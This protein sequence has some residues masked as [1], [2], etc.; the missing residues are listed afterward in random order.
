MKFRPIIVDNKLQELTE[1][2]TEE[3]PMSMDE[4][5]VSYENC[6]EVLHWHYEIQIA[7]VTKGSVLFR[8]P[9]GEFLIKTGQGIFINSGCLHEAVPTDDS[10]SVYICIN[11]HPSLIFG[12]NSSVIRRDYVDPVLFS[13]EIQVIPLTNETWHFEI[14]ETIRKLAG[15]NDAQ[16]YGYE[17]SIKILLCSI[18]LLIVENNRPIIEGTASITFLG[19]QRMR[20]LLHFIQR[21]YM[22]SI[23]LDDIANAVH[24]S[25]GECCRIFKRLQ[26]T[27]PF[28]YLISFRVAQSIKLLSTTDYSIAQIAQQVG[29]GSSS[30]YNECFKKEMNCTPSQ[31]RKNLHGARSKKPDKS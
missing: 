8:T 23:S 25:K 29:F 31:Y 7:L 21:N 13:S 27:T 2:G 26:H 16:Q 18:W 20:A 24:I 5:H 28:L 15:V 14:C 6:H 12:Q 22:D 1:H 9:A 11:F 3:F 4:Q 19:K 10:D 17:I 30:Y